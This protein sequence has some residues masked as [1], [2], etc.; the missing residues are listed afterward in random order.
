MNDTK[1]ISVFLATDLHRR[2]KV[3]A[4]Q[5]GTSLQEMMA[6]AA[7]LMASPPQGA[8]TSPSVFQVR[9]LSPEDKMQLELKFKSILESGDQI[10]I[11]NCTATTEAMKLWI[12]DRP[13]DSLLT[14]PP[15]PGAA[16]GS[17]ADNL[18][19]LK[20]NRSKKAGG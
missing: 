5:R 12:D 15:R 13:S 17:S 18:P 11:L 3:I 20:P 9:S 1:K 10:A 2:L 6:S 4:A 16:A 19:R 8:E 7:E 14:M